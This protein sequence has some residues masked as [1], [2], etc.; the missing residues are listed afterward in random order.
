M[1]PAPTPAAG[2]RGEIPVRCRMVSIIV[3]RGSDAATRTLAMHRVGGN[4]GGIWSYV[5]GHI[6]AGES[7]A[8]A[9]RR[10]L[11]EETGLVPASFWATTF[12]ERFYEP[13]DDCIDIV[14]AFVARA[15]DDAEVHLNGEHSAARWV[16]LAEAR[17]LFPFGS[18]RD[19]LLHVEREFVAREP[20]PLLRLD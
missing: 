1:E 16:S 12:C 20:S 10:E 5:G 19:L 15:G 3:L 2:S 14:P 11:R 6:E 13:A 17:E 18:Q 9:A 7:A 8:Q 4:L